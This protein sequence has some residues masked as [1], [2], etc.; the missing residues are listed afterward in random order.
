YQRQQ[1][2]DGDFQRR[3]VAQV[4]GLGDLNAIQAVVG[5][6]VE[7]APGFIV[8]DDVAVACNAEDRQLRRIRRAREDAAVA[9]SDLEFQRRLVNVLGP[10]DGGQAAGEF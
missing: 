7:Q 6:G 9:A 10:A 8:A 5:N 2:L 1:G 3:P 4:D